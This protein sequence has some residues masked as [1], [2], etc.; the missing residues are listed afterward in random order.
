MSKSLQDQFLKM[1]LVDEKQVKKAK[2]DKRKQAKQAKAQGKKAAVTPDESKLRAQQAQEEKAKR[3][4]ALNLQRQQDAERKAL[5]AQIRQ[6]IEQN[7][8]SREKGESP[9]NFVDGK[10]VKKI[11]VPDNI[12]EQLSAGRL[13]IV[14]LDSDYDIVPIAIAERI[15][16]RDESVFVVL[17]EKSTAVEEDDPYADYQIPDDLMW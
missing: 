10:T 12:L 17:H 1:G 15:K 6:L 3:D 16:Q 7:R 5:Q 11:Y 2:K 4:R 13:A 8:I 14:R 9:Y